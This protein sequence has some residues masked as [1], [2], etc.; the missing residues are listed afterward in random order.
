[1]LVAMKM[2]PYG[3]PAMT[4]AVAG[5]PKPI[6]A[7]ARM[8]VQIPA[9]TLIDIEV[10]KAISSADIDKGS[11]ITFMVSH[12]IFVNGVLVI[13]RGAVATAW[14]IKS[15]RAGSRGQG[16][17]FEFAMENVVAVDGSRILIQLS[18]EVTWGLKK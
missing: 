17:R 16:S 3:P 13:D 14:A 12:R 1:V 8:Q 2:V 6:L 11:P 4:I 7:P 9:G 10:A 15:Q 5:L 18:N